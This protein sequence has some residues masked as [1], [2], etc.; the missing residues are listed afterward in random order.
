MSKLART[1]TSPTDAPTAD[2]PSDSDLLEPS[3]SAGWREVCTI[4]GVATDVEPVP[5]S[6]AAAARPDRPRRYR[7]KHLLGVST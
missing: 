5:A 4:L 1:T 6:I 3:P 7:E 2:Q